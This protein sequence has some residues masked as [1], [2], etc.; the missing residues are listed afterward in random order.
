MTTLCPT[1]VDADSAKALDKMRPGLALYAGFFPRYNKLNASLGFESEAAAIAE[2]WAAGDKDGAAAAVTDAMVRATSVAGS[3]EEC[4]AKLQAYRES[5]IDEPIISPFAR[6][7]DSAAVFEE[8][9]RA[10]AP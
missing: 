9:I 7:P 10:C 1:S 8:A 6:G 4:R 5:G 3:P 2:K